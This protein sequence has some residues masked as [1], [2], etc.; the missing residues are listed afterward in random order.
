MAPIAVAVSGEPDAVETATGTE[1]AGP[2]TQRRGRGRR[3]IAYVGR[4]IWAGLISSA[5][6]VLLVG[7]LVFLSV[8]GRTIPAPDW[9][10]ERA[11]GRINAALAGQGRVDLQE[12]ELF[13]DKGMV[14]RLRLRDTAI[15]TGGGQSLALLPDL[16]A[17]LDGAALWRGAVRPSH[18]RITGGVLMA[19]RRQDGSFDLAVTAD[20]GANGGVMPSAEGA[21]LGQMLDALDAAFATPALQGLESAEV[22][23]LEIVLEDDRA[24]R[25]W[26]VRDGT[27]DFGQ[28]E[29]N[30]AIALGFDLQSDDGANL[31]SSRSETAPARADLAVLSNKSDGRASFSAEVSGVASADLA[32]QVPALAFLAALDAPISGQ[33][34]GGL[35]VAG[36]VGPIEGNL[37]IGRG[38][39]QP[40]PATS[41]V[42]FD[43]G[44]LGFSYDPLSQ[45]IR[46]TQVA[47]DSKTLRVRAEGQAYLR[48]IVGGLPRELQGQVRLSDV[49]VDPQ[50]VFASPVTIDRGAVDLRLRLDPFT[51]DLGQVALLDEQ[52]RIDAHGQ[53]KAGEAGWE[54]RLDIAVDSIRHD[55]LLALWPVSLVPNTRRWI[56]ENVQE[57]LLDN[58]RAALRIIPGAP[59]RATVSYEF[60]DGDVRILKTLPPILAGNGYATVTDSAYTMYLSKGYIDSPQ[61]G[62]IDAAGSVFSV[63]DITERPALAAIRLNTDSTIT[64]AL[65]L[66]DQPPFN[67]VSK[68]GRDV[69]IA[70]GRARLRTEIGLR[71]KKKVLI[72]EVT[73]QVTG[74]LTDVSSDRIVPGRELLAKQLTVSAGRAGMEIAGPGSLSGV[75][76]DARWSQGFAREE[77]GRSTLKG[78]IELSPQALQAFDIALPEGSVGGKGRGEISVELARGKAPH[79][80]LSSDL[81]GLVLKLDGTGWSKP[82]SGRGRLELDATLGSPPTVSRLALD[83]DGLRAEGKIDLRAAGGLDVAKLS[84][85]ALGNW[86][87]GSVALVGQGKGRD[88]RLE[89]TGGALDIR[90]LPTGT[91]GGGG[92]LTV[93]LDTLQ[94]SDGIRLNGFRG[95]FTAAAGG[96]KGRFSGK[97]NG[98]ASV[99]GSV[100]PS[101]GGMAMRVTSDDAGGV[102]ASAGIFSK[103]RGGKL[104]LVL[105]PRGSP[106]DYDGRVTAN[107]L[108]VKK[109]PVLAD[110]LSAISVIGLLEQ[111]NG[112]GLSFSDVQGDFRLTPDALEIRRGSAVGVSLGV[113]MSGVYDLNSK[114]MNFQGVVSPIY[115]VNGIGALVSRRG[116]GLFGFNYRISGPADNPRVGVNPLSVLTP[117]MFRELFRRPPPRL[118]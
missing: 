25:V 46:F 83:A 31:G 61:G 28:T 1:P 80:H 26:R 12:V 62:R 109:A 18:L 41:P 70:E 68:A 45:S 85:V 48:D 11:E 30:L 69:D 2:I 4:H 77:A 75:P 74:S 86:F 111:L 60:R 114:R 71:L 97:V 103:G 102:F 40:A 51:I 52:G 84:R 24:G 29:G 5:V 7:G 87:D 32:A 38:V 112:D 78:Q 66:L 43:S 79:L 3:F 82:A 15:S 101:K 94:I 22:T 113:S 6:L 21:S 99:L 13:I 88:A 34:S 107:G 23:G 9:L 42:A 20:A 53:I 57:G 59:L 76:F 110:L 14:P 33:I 50:G 95:E 81:S 58:V 65:S 117:G 63:P 100:A 35:D 98:G 92:P 37:E 44:K 96:L 55:R 89:V 16:R 73:Y 105:A 72:E 27:L 93:A 64:A 90:R 39:L 54:T 67:F 17:T 47:V 8:T 118:E 104:D 56:E 49:R 36:K 116:E 10:V 19:H 106:G 108:R 115:L 91:G